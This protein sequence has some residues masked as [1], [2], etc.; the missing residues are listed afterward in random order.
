MSS[1]NFSFLNREISFNN[2]SIIF[3]FSQDDLETLPGGSVSQN[4]ELGARYFVM[5]CRIYSKFVLTILLRFI[6]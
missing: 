6:A 1:F 4:V 3:K 5:L 2:P